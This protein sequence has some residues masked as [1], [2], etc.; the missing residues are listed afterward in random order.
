M[1][2]A[3]KPSCNGFSAPATLAVGKS[4]YNINQAL[5][6][7]HEGKAEDVVAFLFAL[8]VVDACFVRAW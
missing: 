4:A 7:S 2:M 3:S 8:C 5:T 6:T 1:L